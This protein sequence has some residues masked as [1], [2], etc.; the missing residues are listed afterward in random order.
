MPSSTKGVFLVKMTS[1][2]EIRHGEYSQ[3]SKS[4]NRN[5]KL[6]LIHGS[7][8]FLCNSNYIVTPE[9]GDMYLFPNYLMHSV[10]PFTGTEEERRS[11]SF[12]A[13]I[14]KN[15]ANPYI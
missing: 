7:K 11:V 15:V 13:F 1:D 14:D 8:M 4:L 12:N 5:G 10:Y 6:D 2:Q 9:V 3:D